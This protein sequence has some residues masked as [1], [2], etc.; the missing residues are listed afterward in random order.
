MNT[1]QKPEWY[2]YPGW[3]LLTTV[4][5]PVAFFLTLAILRLVIH[6]VG[7]V[8]YVN[9]VRHISEDFLAIYIFMPV[10]GL[11]MGLLQYGLLSR[12]LARMGGWVLGTAD[13]WILGLVLIVTGSWLNPWPQVPLDFR[14]VFIVLG[15]S[16]G[17]LQWLLLRRRLPRAGW[18]VLASLLGWGLLALFSEQTANEYALILVGLLPACVTAATFG[19]LLNREE[20]LEAQA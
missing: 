2:F 16:I 4:C 9:G 10:V 20:P 8:I 11:L 19:L 5:V 17:V 15:L 1:T 7:D 18:W 3:I 13:G 14:L 12:Y 6:F